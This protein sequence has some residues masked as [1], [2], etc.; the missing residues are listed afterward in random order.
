[1]VLAD[2]TPRAGEATAPEDPW[3][4]RITAAMRLIG[5]GDFGTATNSAGMPVPGSAGRS[6]AF[7]A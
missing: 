1:M 6:E 7:S 4:A 3:I 5:R 2:E